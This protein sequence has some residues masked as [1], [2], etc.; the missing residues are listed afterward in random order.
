MAVS[1]PLW[2]NEPSCVAAGDCAVALSL[3]WNKLIYNQVHVV[4]NTKHEVQNKT[5]EHVGNYNS[6]VQK[7]RNTLAKLAILTFSDFLSM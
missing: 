5:S 4:K 3:T 1:G 7:G 2:E 6:Q